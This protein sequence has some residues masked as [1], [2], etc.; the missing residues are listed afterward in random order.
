MRIC[1]LFR[2]LWLSLLLLNSCASAP[3]VFKPIDNCRVSIGGILFSCVDNTGTPYSIAP[4]SDP[5]K[6]LVCFKAEDFATFNE[7]C[8]N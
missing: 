6:D 4:G 5:A 3:R 8:H 1:S 7:V 2:P